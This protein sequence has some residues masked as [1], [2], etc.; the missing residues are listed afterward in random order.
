MNK[1]LVVLFIGLLL[2]LSLAALSQT[3]ELK[4]RVIVEQANVRLKPDL[5][6]QILSQVP[7]G[8]ILKVESKMGEWFLV[9]LPADEKGFVLSGYIHQSVVEGIGEKVKEVPEVKREKAEVT[10]QVKKEKPSAPRVKPSVY[11]PERAEAGAKSSIGIRAGYAMLSEEKYGSG[12]EYGVNLSFGL[13]KNIGI[14]ISGLRFQSDVE[15][16]PEA[17]SKGKLSSIPVQLSIQGRFPINDQI[18]PYVLGGAGYYLNSFTIDDEIS[19]DWDS[20]GVDI[21]EKMDSAIGFHFGAG[22]DFFFQENIALNADFRYCI[23]KTKGSWTMTEQVGGVETSGEL[24]D[25][26]LNSIM[27]GVGLKFCF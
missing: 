16:D 21:E 2:L 17:L 15:E 11:A 5:T 25:L 7:L 22:V 20:V 10:P 26:S 1:K 8:T 4:V 14:E 27:F 3:S 9:S 24:E 13:S 19:A 6:S 23:A 12:L 18:V